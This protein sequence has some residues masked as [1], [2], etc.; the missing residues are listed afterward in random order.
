MTQMN[1]ADFLLQ[2]DRRTFILESTKS[3]KEKYEPGKMALRKG[4]LLQEVAKSIQ[5]MMAL[6]QNR[7]THNVNGSTHNVNGSFTAGNVHNSPSLKKKQ[8]PAVLEVNLKEEYHKRKGTL[9]KQA[10]RLAK[11]TISIAPPEPEKLA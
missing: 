3:K 2:E 7:S 10:T 6:E 5:E 11:K 9:P 4:A 8:E 1:D